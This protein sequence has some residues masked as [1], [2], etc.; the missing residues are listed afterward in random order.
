MSPSSSGSCDAPFP[1]EWSAGT[2]SRK[3]MREAYKPKDSEDGLVL[4]AAEDQLI[5]HELMS[6]ESVSVLLSG[7]IA[8]SSEPV[9]YLITTEEFSFWGTT[10][11]YYLCNYIEEIPGTDGGDDTAKWYKF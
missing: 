7:S 10:L 4:C 8:N 9:T 2:G 1:I 11:T 6:S 3:Y 5:T